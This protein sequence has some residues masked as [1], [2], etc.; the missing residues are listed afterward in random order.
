MSRDLHS[1]ESL[2]PM[3]E[4]DRCHRRDPSLIN[5]S[6]VSKIRSYQSLSNKLRDRI[7]L[8]MTWRW[9]LN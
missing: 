8:R 4:G 6:E 7:P 5:T 3:L 2:E 1:E 9:D